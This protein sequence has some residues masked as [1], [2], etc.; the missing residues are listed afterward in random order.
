MESY[1]KEIVQ[2]YHQLD[3]YRTKDKNRNKISFS[4]LTVQECLN[5]IKYNVQNSD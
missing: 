2:E 5:Y 1:E 4:D 3:L